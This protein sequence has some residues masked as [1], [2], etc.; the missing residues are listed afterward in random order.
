MPS[1]STVPDL[2][3]K[4]NG[5][6]IP[7]DAHGDIA[8]VRVEED[9]DALSM[10]TVELVNW[11]DEKLQ[12]SWS[13]ASLFA[14]GNEVEIS[15]GFVDDLHKV[16]LGEITSLEP[17]FSA[18]RPPTLTVRGFDLRHR[19]GRGRKTRTFSKMKDSAIATQVAQGAGLRA[20]VTDSQNV[21]EYVAQ[22]NQ[23]DLEFLRARARLIGYEVFVRDKVLFFRPP[24]HAAAPAL[25]LTIGLDITEFTP[26]LS[27]LGQVGGTSVRGWD[28]KTK[29]AVVGTSAVEPATMGGTALG[30]KRADRAFGR[31]SRVYVD[32]PVPDR[33]RAD[34]VARGQY[35]DMAL[36]FIQG[37][38][39]GPG[40]PQVQ[41]GSVVAVT[42]AGKTFSGSY[43]VTSVTHSLVT[44]EG[45]RTSFDVRR[46]AV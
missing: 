43:Y 14:V 21:L 1:D 35:T 15:L 45:F 9:L 11:D 13:D 23:S 40:R 41:A 29:H 22:S 8:S 37:E 10:F 24:Q 25:R 4:V 39:D 2:A 19:L 20:R 42:G 33:A 18:D 34:Q 5:Q 32:I 6:R 26:R 28:A 44:N 27:A 16:M 3:I 17:T 38:A 30:S 46:T 7:M 36:S 12:F 31:S